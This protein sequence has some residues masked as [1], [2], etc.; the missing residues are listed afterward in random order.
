MAPAVESPVARPLAARGRV[1]FGPQWCRACR[2]CEV[3]CA[4]GKEGVARPSVARISIMFDEF[5]ERDPVSG[6]ICAQCEDAPC[7]EACPAG[8]MRRDTDTGAI[9]INEED[10]IGCM[11]CAEACPWEVPSLHPGREVALKCDLCV[12]R[13]GGPLCIKACPLAG[14]ALRYEKSSF[15]EGGGDGAV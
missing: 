8:A 10:C 13:K 7:M 1:V 11:T 15:L 2:V 12:G 4:I 3:A 6:T 5:A 14:K 9:V